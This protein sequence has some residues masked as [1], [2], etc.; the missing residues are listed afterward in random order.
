MSPF[1]KMSATNWKLRHSTISFQMLLYPSI[2]TVAADSPSQNFVRP[3]WRRGDNW[4]SPPR[5]WTETKEVLSAHKSYDVLKTGLSMAIAIEIEKCC[6]LVTVFTILKEARDLQHVFS[7]QDP[8]TPWH[9]HST[10]M[11]RSKS[12]KIENVCFNYRIDNVLSLKFANN[13]VKN[14]F[15]CDFDV[16]I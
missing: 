3:G 7:S 8:L 13:W 6:S 14:P 15:S 4:P 9:L 11:V 16:L 12:W 10:F 5:S 2:Y 1:N